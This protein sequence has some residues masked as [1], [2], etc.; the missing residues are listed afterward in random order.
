MIFL[1]SR[2][3][4][5]FWLHIECIMRKTIL[6]VGKKIRRIAQAGK[7]RYDRLLGRATPD[8]TNTETATAGPLK[9]KSVAGGEALLGQQ[10][11]TCRENQQISGSGKIQRKIRVDAG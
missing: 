6:S 1:T 7:H 10:F 4:A 5:I 2:D 9:T 11:S 3:G 8:I